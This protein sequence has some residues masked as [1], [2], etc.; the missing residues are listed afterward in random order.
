[1]QLS[2][3]L[4][5]FAFPPRLSAI[6]CFVHYIFSEIPDIAGFHQ[7]RILRTIN[8]EQIGEYWG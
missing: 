8:N 3:S 1:M 4:S 5:R 7:I 2:H 6:R